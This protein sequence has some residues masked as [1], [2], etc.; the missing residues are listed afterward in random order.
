MGVLVPELK[1][2]KQEASFQSRE[3]PVPAAWLGLM[4]GVFSFRLL[5]WILS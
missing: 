4:G 3:Q 2:Q 1:T 5:Y